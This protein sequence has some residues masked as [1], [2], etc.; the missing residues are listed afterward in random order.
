MLEMERLRTQEVERRIE[1]PIFCFEGPGS[2][3]KSLLSTHVGENLRNWGFQTIEIEEPIAVVDKEGKTPLWKG[4]TTRDVFKLKIL[5]RGASLEG[6]E[7]TQMLAALALRGYLYRDYL[8][9]LVTEESVLLVGRGSFSTLVYQ[10]LLDG[11]ALSGERG[12]FLES[13]GVLGIPPAKLT[14]ILLPELGGQQK[15]LEKRQLLQTNIDAYDEVK[16]QARICQD[17]NQIALHPGQF[18]EISLTTHGLPAADVATYP[19]STLELIVSLRVLV[20]LCLGNPSS[21]ERFADK[22]NIFSGSNSDK[23]RALV[24]LNA[25]FGVMEKSESRWPIEDYPS[26]DI[27]VWLNFVL[28]PEPRFEGIERRIE[29]LKKRLIN[30][31]DLE[32]GWVPDYSTFELTWDEGTAL[33]ERKNRTGCKNSFL[34]L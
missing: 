10:Q 20:E 6:Q 18:R 29:G 16:K 19:I 32:L 4:M 22:V 27:S 9:P 1:C 15:R 13:L 21:Y 26:D 8:P 2:S 24:D 23:G 14:F 30:I 7:Y 3:G 33:A 11:R 12:L 31:G 34:E 5:A 25:L 28:L 17:Y